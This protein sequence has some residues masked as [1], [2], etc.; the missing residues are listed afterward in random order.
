MALGGVG[1][2]TKGCPTKLFN[3]TINHQL[4]E[5]AQSHVISGALPP[6]PPSTMLTKTG[7]S[8]VI[9]ADT[10]LNLARCPRAGDLQRAYSMYAPL[11]LAGNKEQADRAA[12]SDQVCGPCGHVEKDTPGG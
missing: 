2:P 12:I 4:V 10:L 7:M 5:Y 6:P 9:S 3:L 11:L 1:C 8:L